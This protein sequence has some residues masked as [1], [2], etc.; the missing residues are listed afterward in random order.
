MAKLGSIG[1]Q[2]DLI[3]KKGSDFGYY[4]M[5]FVNRQNS[6]PYD[7][8]DYTFSGKI[9]K[10]INSDTIIASIEILPVDLENGVVAIGISRTETSKL[11]GSCTFDEYNEY[12]WDLE[13]ISPIGRIEPILYGKVKVYGDV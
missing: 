13:L 1:K 4:N 8:T 12:F 7:L 9:K 6:E 2:L 5:T 10:N 11:K 3:V